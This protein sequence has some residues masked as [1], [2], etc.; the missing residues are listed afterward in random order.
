MK[1]D[2]DDL[3][4]WKQLAGAAHLFCDW[5]PTNVNWPKQ[6]YELINKEISFL[7]SRTRQTLT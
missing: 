7:F 4:G 5:L 3:F 6:N 1:K 2:P